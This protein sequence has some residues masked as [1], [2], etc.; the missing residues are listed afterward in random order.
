[1]KKKNIPKANKKEKDKHVGTR[2]YYN[3]NSRQW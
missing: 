3:H 1:M 2:R